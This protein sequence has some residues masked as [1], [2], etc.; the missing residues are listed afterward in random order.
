MSDKITITIKDPI[1]SKIRACHEASQ[2]GT[3]LGNRTR[4]EKFCIEIIENFISDNRKRLLG[5][6]IG[7]GR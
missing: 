1:A 7:C 2:V 5:G 3:E 6:K 4:V